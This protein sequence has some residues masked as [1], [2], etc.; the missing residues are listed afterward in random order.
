MTAAR[1]K[2]ILRERPYLASDAFV[3]SQTEAARIISVR[4]CPDVERVFIKAKSKRVLTDEMCADIESAMAR[5]ERRQSGLYGLLVGTGGFAAK[6]GRAVAV[7]CAIVLLACFMC[8]TPTGRALAHEVGRIVVSLFDDGFAISAAPNSTAM[9]VEETVTEFG[10][11]E[12][13]EKATG[14]QAVRQA[15][16]VYELTGLRYYINISGETLEAVYVDEAGR[17]IDVRQKWNSPAAAY[18]DKSPDIAWAQCKTS[19]GFTVDYY[20]DSGDNSFFGIAALSDS[21]M[22][23]IAEADV[24][25]DDFVANI[26]ID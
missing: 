5:A 10:S 12:E 21:S 22:V 13:F 2:S 11:I 16:G 7:M 1:L 20:I 6:H 15:S 3:L 23:V 19:S 14:R 25:Y 4:G 26:S 8:F 24:L 9:P 18:G 17:Q